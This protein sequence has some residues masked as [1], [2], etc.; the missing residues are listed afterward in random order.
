MKSVTSS[1]SANRNLQGFTLI[2]ILIS[3]AIVAILAAIAV[4]AYKSYIFKSEIRAAQA[5]LL[6]LSLNFENRYQRTLAYPTFTDTQKANTAGIKDVMKGWTTS[7][8]N[9]NF[10]VEQVA[11][12]SYKIVAEGTDRQDGCKLSLTQTNERSS[13]GCQYITSGKWL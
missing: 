3:V 12:S 8:S 4:P 9:F 13:S 6:A 11:S 10:K 2:E 7:A 5:D 1:K